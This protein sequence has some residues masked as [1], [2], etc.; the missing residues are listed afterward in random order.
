MPLMRDASAPC[1]D[2]VGEPPRAPRLAT[3]L[4]AMSSHHGMRRPAGFDLTAGL[5]AMA[6][7]PRCER[8]RC[9]PTTHNRVA[10]TWGGRTWS[11]VER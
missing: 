8:L 1:C 10:N 4:D 2:R 6:N 5:A 7:A 9:T 11:T 3:P